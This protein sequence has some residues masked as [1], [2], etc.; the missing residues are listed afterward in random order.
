MNNLLFDLKYSLRRLARSPVFSAII[1]LTLALGI[2]ANSAIFSIVNTV[3]LTPAPYREP[4]QLV[5]VFH[6]YEN[7]KLHAG[8]SA[9]GFHAYRDETHDFDAVAV[10]TGWGVNLTGVGD[11][12][13]LTGV[14]ASGD[15]WKVLGVPP[16]LG[17][18]FGRDEDAVSYTHLTLP[19]KRIV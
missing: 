5:E 8:V 4:A 3:L 6:W 19:T 11:P 13:R 7:L 16:A 17:R 2:G 10:T 9:P 1:I 12:Q 14:R 15:F 18:V